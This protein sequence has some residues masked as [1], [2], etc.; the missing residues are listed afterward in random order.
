PGRHGYCVEHPPEGRNAAFDCIRGWPR[1]SATFPAAA[2]RGQRRTTSTP[3]LSRM[4]VMP[5]ASPAAEPTGFTAWVIDVMEA[6]GGPGAGLIIALENLFP[7]IP[8]EA[9]LPLAG[10]TASRGEMSLIGAIV[11]TMR[12]G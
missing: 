8:S 6:L 3:E 9:I 7:P 10:F 12:G 2:V 11:W 1:S 5:L 4:Q